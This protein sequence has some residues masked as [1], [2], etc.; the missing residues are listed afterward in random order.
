[1]ISTK[2]GSDAPMR[3]M[4]PEYR[5]GGQKPIDVQRPVQPTPT[6]KDCEA[7]LLQLWDC[8]YWNKDSVAIKNVSA[9]LKE[10]KGEQNTVEGHHSI[11][12][13]I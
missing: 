5:K 6:V 3:P 10:A 13:L 1:M 11:D 8:G 7:K 12:I 9:D 2:I 4:N